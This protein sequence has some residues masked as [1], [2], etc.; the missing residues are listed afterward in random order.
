MPKNA[1]SKL[2]KFWVF[3]SLAV[4]LFTTTCDVAILLLGVEV[5]GLPRIPCVTA[6]VTF[7]AFIGFWLNKLFA[8]RDSGQWANQALR[9]VLL[10]LTE[11]GLHTGLSSLLLYQFG[12]HYLVAKFSSDAL[13]FG[14][15]HLVAMRYLV[16]RSSGYTPGHRKEG[17]QTSPSP[18]ASKVAAR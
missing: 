2:R 1:F 18:V 7:G 13:V 10:L 9:Y 8:F 12:L 5:L 6:G 11:I 16:F 15:L 3:R 17:T 14:M 4:G